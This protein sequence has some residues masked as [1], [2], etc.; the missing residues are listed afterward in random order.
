MSKK[1]EDITKEELIKILTHFTKTI[2]KL[3]NKLDVITQ[4][5]ELND[6]PD[7]ID[8]ENLH[9]DDIP[10]PIETLAEMGKYLG[11]VPFFLGIT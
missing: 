7:E 8:I 1:K 10:F 4:A 3:D 6:M 5:I 11:K 2:A 9:G